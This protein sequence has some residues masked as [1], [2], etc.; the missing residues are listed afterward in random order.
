MSIQRLDST[1]TYSQNRCPSAGRSGPAGPSFQDRLTQT[2]GKARDT[3]AETVPT[4][5][6]TGLTGDELLSALFDLKLDRMKLGKE[7]K[8]EEDAWNK[9]MAYL[10]AWIESLREEGSIEKVARAHAALSALQADA[11]SGRK[12]LGDHLLEQLENMNA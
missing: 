7:K 4:S 5:S 9:L 12:D 8:E 1:Q 11:E 6:Q 10:D 3:Q 2:A